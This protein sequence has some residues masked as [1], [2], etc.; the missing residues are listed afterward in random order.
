MKRIFHLSTCNT[1]QKII[2]ELA[3][4]PEITLQDIKTEPIT[5]EQLDHMKALA[6]SY[7]T[8]F[9]RRAIKFRSMGLK[10]MTL[11]EDDYRKYILQEYTFLRRPVV[12]LEDQIRADDQVF[13]RL[14]DQHL[15]W[16]GKR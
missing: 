2:K 11:S 16:P 8:L 10:E 4:G 14:R 13:H 7:E 3:P 5:P 12:V 9:S 15:R 6:G 1:C